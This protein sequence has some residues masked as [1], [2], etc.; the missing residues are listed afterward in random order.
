MDKVDLKPD[1]LV[2]SRA[3]G[4]VYIVERLTDDYESLG[5]SILARRVDGDMLLVLSI[6]EVVPLTDIETL[7]YCGKLQQRVQLLLG[8]VSNPEHL[9]HG[10]Q[11]AVSSE[12]MTNRADLP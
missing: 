8:A 7:V 9:L 6:A 1:T 11:S 3:N 5:T 12:A 10:L 4:Q 2:R